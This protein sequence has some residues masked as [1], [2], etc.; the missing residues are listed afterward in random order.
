MRLSSIEGKIEAM[1]TKMNELEQQAKEK[2]QKDEFKS[3]KSRWQSQLDEVK[4]KLDQASEADA[5]HQSTLVT[6]MENA[7]GELED[8]VREAERQL[9]VAGMSQKA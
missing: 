4:Q 1:Q 5:G 9:G 3:L 6:S 8:I 7:V 2:G